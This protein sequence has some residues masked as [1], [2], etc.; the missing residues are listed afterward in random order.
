MCVI[1]LAAT[2]LT[3][4]SP[5]YELSIQGK[6]TA[7]VDEAVRLTLDGLPP[8]EW[9]LSEEDLEWLNALIVKVSAPH[10][11]DED[12]YEM[13]QELVLKLAPVRFVFRLE[14]KASVAG[15]YVFAVDWNGEP[16][17]LLLHRLEVGGGSDPPPGP[18]PPDPP[19]PP[20][21]GIFHIVIFYESG[22]LEEKDKLTDQQVQM[23]ASLK[24]KKTLEQKGHRLWTFDSDLTGPKG[25]PEAWRP[26]WNALEGHGLPA[27]VLGRVEDSGVVIRKTHP[28]PKTVD[29]LWELI[30]GKP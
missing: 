20:T 28:L 17:E 18:D 21:P 25:M 3:A 27:V 26:W 24:F 23:I 16:K 2:L 6:T 1:L 29:G 4:E 22:D 12:G 10:A 7:E 11:V 8:I 9:P 15:H 30:G 5:P 13:E 19:D 14:F